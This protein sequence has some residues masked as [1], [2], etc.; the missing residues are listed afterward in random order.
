[1]GRRTEFAPFSPSPQQPRLRL[2]VVGGVVVAVLGGFAL[3]R[4]WDAS[5]PPPAQETAPATG[6][7]T[8]STPDDGGEL[9]PDDVTW[10]EHAGLLMPFSAEHG[11]FEDAGGWVRGFS[12][13]RQGAV[14]A[15]THIFVQASNEADMPEE[16]IRASFDEQLVGEH[17]GA[18]VERMV[19]SGFTPAPAANIKVEGYLVHDYHDNGAVFELA[20]STATEGGDGY[21]IY[22]AT[23][24]TVMWENG[25]WRLLVP[26][27]TMEHVRL[28]D[29]TDEFTPFPRDE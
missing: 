23:M 15:G 1:M 14:M 8:P 19:A 2:L 21:P 13:T 17:A 11:P 5:E 12:R 29:T 20:A 22:T 4:V 7:P 10:R 28:L 9:S 3:G 27:S 25:D 24:L 16:A 18:F 26:E 6:D